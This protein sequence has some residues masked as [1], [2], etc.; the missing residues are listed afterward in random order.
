M[1]SVNSTEPFAF[2]SNYVTMYLYAKKKKKR[3]EE[4]YI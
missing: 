3:K 2:S 1:G 4:V